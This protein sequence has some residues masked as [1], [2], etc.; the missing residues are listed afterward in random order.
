M[1]SYVKKK[2]KN[3]LEFQIPKGKTIT[4]FTNETNKAKDIYNFYNIE[5]ESMIFNV[6][7]VSL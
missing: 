3:N 6:I 2:K 4:S 1:N 5:Y 7:S